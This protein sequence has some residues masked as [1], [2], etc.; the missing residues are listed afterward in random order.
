MKNMKRILGLGIVLAAFS[1]AANAQ[2][3]ATATATATIVTPISITKVTDM[4]FGN[5]AVQA[6]AGGTV[7]LDTA[8]VRTLTGTGLTL[9]NVTGTVAAASFTVAGT[10]NYTYDITLPTTVTLTHSGGTATMAASAF[11]S[12][13]VTTGALSATGSQLL[14]VG[15]TLTV[16]ANQLAGV[17]TSG[18]FNVTVNY[19]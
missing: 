4:S 6:S 18:N 12:D 13:P 8:S 16:A 15:A 3:T 10:A 9:P 17:Y 2:A 11:N 1:T 5:I 19:N 7:K 14:R